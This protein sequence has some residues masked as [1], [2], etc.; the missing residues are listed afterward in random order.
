MSTDFIQK[1]T[2]K[3]LNDEKLTYPLNIAMTAAWIM[4]NFKGTNL[5]IHDVRKM[6][7]MADYFIICSAE[8][9]TQAMAIA[10][11]IARMAKANDEVIISQEGRGESDW[12]LIDLANVIIHIFLETARDKYALD[13]LWAKAPLVSIPES[14]YFS[15]P[16][17]DKKN[18]NE[19]QGN[20]F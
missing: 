16:E 5:K 10:D 8:N 13:E 15:H 1:E 4:G 3:I 17:M 19:P 14:Y 7:A 12:V 18:V 2:A 6:T 20:Y 9:P 11:E